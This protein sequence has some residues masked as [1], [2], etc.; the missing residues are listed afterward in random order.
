[1]KNII[2]YNKPYDENI[3]EDN[4]AYIAPTYFDF[5]F[6]ITK[7]INFDKEN[8]SFDIKKKDLVQMKE[9]AENLIEYIET[10][11]EKNQTILDKQYFIRDNI[12]EICKS[13]EYVSFDPSLSV[14]E[15]YKL[16]TTNSFFK[17]KKLVFSTSDDFPKDLLDTILKLFKNNINDIYFAVSTN[18]SILHIND[19]I[20]TLNKIEEI[21]AE[22]NKFNFSPF[23]KILYLYDVVK[24][25]IYT[26]ESSDEDSTLSRNINSALLGEKIVCE[27]YAKIYKLLLDKANIKSSISSLVDKNDDTSG[28]VR[29]EIYIK[30]EK[31]GI[32][33]VLFF[34]PTWDS[35]LD[36]S[37]NNF[38]L[39]YNHFALSANEMF[40]KDE[41][42]NL[43]NADMPDNNFYS[44]VKLIHK[45]KNRKDHEDAKETIKTINHMSRV[46]NEKSLIELRDYFFHRYTEKDYEK[47]EKDINELCYKYN[48]K[49]N[50]STMLKALFNVRKIQYYT[51]P[52]KYPFTNQV[53]YAFGLLSNRSPISAEIKLFKSIFGVEISNKDIKNAIINQLS[54]NDIPRKVKQVQFTKLLRD[55]KNNKERQRVK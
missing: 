14:E 45:I 20:E 52:E 33:G 53:F 36:E 16:Y 15:V 27:G 37:D 23:E 7:L 28:H 51:N 29:N 44:S 1:M 31:Y 17:N 55:I 12:E 4:N 39:R 25:R 54:R 49:V 42:N 9:D 11:D 32:D 10:S 35:K 3:C 13:I 8:S 34:D 2:I 6:G 40:N 50:Y 48:Q 21:V 46:V 41:E 38:L 43:R 22:M 47:L 5:D 30:D 24:E 18:K 19:Y 26:E